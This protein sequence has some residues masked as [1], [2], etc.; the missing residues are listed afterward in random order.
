L[1]E[2]Q[3]TAAGLKT[4]KAKFFIHHFGHLEA[5]PAKAAKGAYYRDLL[6]LKVQEEPNDAGAWIQLGLQEY[7]H[8]HDAE[9]GLHCLQR[10][11]QL[12]PR[13]QEAWLFLAMI[14]VDSGKAGEAMIALDQDKRTGAS[15]ALREQVRGDALHCLN[16]FAEAR[17]AYRR[18]MKTAANDPMLESKLGYVEMKLGQ[19]TAGMAK[20][21]RAATAVPGMF[22]V[23]DRL[24]KAYIMTGDLQRAATVADHI[25]E[26]ANHPRLFLRAA[27]LYAALPDWDHCLQTLQRGLAAFPDS[28]DL[29]QAHAEASQHTVT[30][31][32]VASSI[33]V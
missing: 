4:G 27:S 14:C 20:V 28:P 30:Q 21:L 16:R 1:V 8:F 31:E 3:I 2:P 33:S 18:A 13:A 10:A 5:S 11:L 32:I 29:L 23:Q 7:E 24:M 12:E 9:R 26:N 6:R 17:M 19:R 25:T 15:N 22:S